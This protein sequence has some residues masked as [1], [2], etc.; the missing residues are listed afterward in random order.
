MI[1]PGQINKFPGRMA[2]KKAYRSIADLINISSSRILVVVMTLILTIGI[3][4]VCS[5]QTKKASTTQTKSTS[6]QD[7]RNTPMPDNNAMV[8]PADRST[9]ATDISTG[10]AMD[11]AI[12]N[13][14]YQQKAKKAAATDTSATKKTAA[15]TTKDIATADKTTP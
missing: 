11:R 15:I 12:A 3:T 5:A 10:S 1:R 13:Y 7:D 6:I 8:I 2:G 14:V 9:T 4:G